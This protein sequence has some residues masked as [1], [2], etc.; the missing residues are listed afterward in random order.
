MSYD[1]ELDLVYYGVGNP[2]PYNAEQRAGDNK[3]TNSVLA[4]R[5]SD[6]SLVWA[7]QFTPHDNWDYDAVATMIL[8][9]IKIGGRTARR[10]SRST[11]TAS[12]TRS[13]V[14]PVR[15]SPLRPSCQ[16]TWARRIDLKT[17]RPI[18]RSDQS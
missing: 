9:D 7:Y 14:P 18:A 13:I 3:W 15:C 10:W 2:S 4:R 12:S 8:A 5:P 6:G 1:P 17:G 16:V 11:R